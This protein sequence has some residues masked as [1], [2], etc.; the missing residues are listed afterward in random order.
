MYK[1]NRRH[2]LLVKPSSGRQSAMRRCLLTMKVDLRIKS[3]KF[4]ST[5]YFRAPILLYINGHDL[6]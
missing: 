3:E 2:E 6:I 1:D 5:I 4:I